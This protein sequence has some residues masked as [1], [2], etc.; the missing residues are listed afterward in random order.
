MYLDVEFGDG[1]ASGT[2]SGRITDGVK[3]GG[4]TLPEITLG[5][6]DIG[7]GG[8]FGGGTSGAASGGAALSGKWGGRFYGDGASATEHPGSAAGTF[9]AA[10]ADGDQS[11]IGAFA[12]YDATPSETPMPMPGETPSTPGRNVLL[13]E[14]N[15][16]SELANGAAVRIQRAADLLPA[17][18][19]YRSSGISSTTQSQFSS[20]GRTGDQLIFVPK[21]D[22]NGELHFT[23]T[24]RIISDGRTFVSES[25]D[26]LS[27][28]ER[29]TDSP[30][31]G[32]NGVEWHRNREDLILNS[33]AYS[34]IQ[35][36]G[37][38]DYLS[39]GTWLF[40]GKDPNTGDY[41]GF[42]NLGA[43][44]TGNDPFDNTGLPA[45][46][47]TATYEGPA[48]GM[49]MSK[50]SSSATPVFDNFDAKANLEANFGDASTLGNISGKHLR[51]ND[52]WRPGPARTDAGL[53]RHFL[54]GRHRAGGGRGAFP[55]HDQ[56]QRLVRQ[57]GRQALRQWR[58]R[59]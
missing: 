22:E 19:T 18:R 37:D 7:G 39:L 32:W 34:D 16:N 24:R 12:A 1:S 53:R 11:I 2:L 56:R 33:D 21:Y 43:A 35:S 9:G 5:S 38:N 17:G 13:K 28:F 29:L 15:E 36:A 47:G 27:S 52:G 46:T 59:D 3:D 55:R 30:A 45:L 54:R 50:A 6:A 57:V 4:E 8:S 20:N 58:G 44:A 42:I 25:N 40:I 51:G 26:P 23:R 41:T 49:Y 14:V 10:T 48:T 31:T